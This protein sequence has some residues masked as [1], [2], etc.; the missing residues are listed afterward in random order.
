MKARTGFAGQKAI[1]FSA[2]VNFCLMINV[3]EGKKKIR[4]ARGNK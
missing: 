3:I 1:E 2:D 4:N